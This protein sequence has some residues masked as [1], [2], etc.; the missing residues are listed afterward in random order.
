MLKKIKKK[1]FY[2]T[3]TKRLKHLMARRFAN[4]IDSAADHLDINVTLSLR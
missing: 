4:S 1:K 3:Y 2:K